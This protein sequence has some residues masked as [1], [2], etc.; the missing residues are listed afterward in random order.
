M[1]AAM[2]AALIVVDVQEGLFRPTPSPASSESVFARINELTSRARAARVPVIFVQHESATDDLEYGTPGWALAKELH[3]QASDEIVRKTTSD[4]FLRTSL[5]SILERNGVSNV[6]VC[7]Y[8]TEFC[9]DTTVRRAA[10]LGYD[11]T[12]VADA[13][14]THDKN[15]AKA[16][17]IVEHH[18]ATLAGIES[19]GPTIQAVATADIRFDAGEALT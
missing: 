4:S 8:A 14:T 10:A 19:F 5:G 18:N 17:W 12:L 6:V 16:A 2:A 9:V 15:H 1:A 7:G 3:V 13:H 11:V